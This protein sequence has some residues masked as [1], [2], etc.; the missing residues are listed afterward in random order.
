MQGLFVNCK[1]GGKAFAP[2]VTTTMRS[3]DYYRRRR[4]I[5]NAAYIFN[6]VL[7]RILQCPKIFRYRPCFFLS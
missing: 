7:K 4:A 5:M 2:I 1:W 3:E 6:K